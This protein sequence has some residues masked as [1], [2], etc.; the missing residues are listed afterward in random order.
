MRPSTPFW[1]SRS[2][3][4]PVN[5]TNQLLDMT[6]TAAVQTILIVD[7]EIQNRK[8]LETLLRPEGYR[9]LTAANGE[10]ALKVIAEHSPD[11]ILLDIMMPGIDGYELAVILKA[12]AA[13]SNI[14]IIMVTA[15]IDRDARLTALNAGAEE[16]LSKPV[17]R[18]ELYLRVRN[19]LRLKT[20]GELQKQAQEEI[21]SLN[22]GL[23]TRVQERTAQLQASNEELQ[24]FAY[25]VSHDLRTPLSSISGFSNLLHREVIEN[26]GTVRSLHYL[27]RIS[28][29][30][31]QMGASIDALLLLTHVSRTVLRPEKVDL[32]AMAQAVLNGYSE[33]EPY[34]L[35]QME[36]EPDLVV[37]GDPYLLRQALAN[38][39]GN[40]WKFSG[41]Q[42]QVSVI[43]S[44][45]TDADGKT[46]YAIKD[47]GSG[48]DMNYYDKLFAPFQRLHSISEFPG[49]GIGLATVHRIVARHG[50]KVWAESEPGCGA[51]FYFSLGVLTGAKEGGVTL[52]DPQDA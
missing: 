3:K 41:Q 38:L 23:E 16:F 49:S 11:L 9:T 13:T 12:D 47:N 15:L 21:R 48:F 31:Q 34:R 2:S 8:L 37:Q 20:F 33:R 7:D 24:A 32:S 10:E 42:T 26:T 43:F 17:D 14:P 39:L 35:V 46:V 22:T 44:S 6:T 51:T 25:S 1:K 27:A 5:K 4:L 29:G 40:A 19:L 52:A 30:V 50:G 18:T 45:A 36:I 28:A